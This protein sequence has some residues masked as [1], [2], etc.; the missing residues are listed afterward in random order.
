MFRRFCTVLFYVVLSF[1]FA[2]L[3]FGCKDKKVY[4]IG[5][6]QCSEDDWRKKMNDEIK[7]EM[8]FHNDAVVEIRSADDNSEK[9]IKDIEYFAKNGFD[10]IVVA[11]NEANALTPV[12]DKV[13]KS[14]IP[15]L[16]FDRNINSESYTAYQGA[17]NIS[18]SRTA[19]EYAKT[20]VKGQCR[21]LEI[22]GLKG[23]TPAD[24]R[25]K[26]FT[27]FVESD[28]NMNI[29]G[30]AYGNWNTDDA[31][32]VADSLIDA[33]PDVNLIYA[34][35]DRMAIAASY[36]IR[37]KGLHDVKIV[38]ID[39]APEIGIKAVMDGVID[40]TFL[41]PTDGYG[42]IRT[43]MSILKGKDYKK[44]TILPTAS[45]VN[46]TN[47]E[48]LLLQNKELQSEANKII[49]LKDR[50]DRYKNELYAQYRFIYAVIAILILSFILIFVI[51]F[52]FKEKKKYQMELA[53]K[54]DLLEK[55][56][57]KEIHLNEEL[58]N[59][60]NSKLMFFTNVSHDLRTPL[61]LIL[62]PILQIYN[63]DNLTNS[64]KSLLRL[65][66]NNVKLL[67]SLIDQIL[68]FHKYENGRL[69]LSLDEVDLS[70]L[71]KDWCDS[72]MNIAVSKDIEYNIIIPDNEDFTL[73]ID[74]EKMERV[75]FNLISN[76]FKYTEP[77]DKITVSINKTDNNVSIEVKDSGIGISENAIKHIFDYSF[78]ESRLSSEGSGIGL[79]IAKSFT[80]LHGGTISVESK[81][82][83]GT[84]FTIY[85][86]IKHIDKSE[87]IISDYKPQEYSDIEI[88]SHDTNAESVDFDKTT[89]LIIDDN[90]DIRSLI[91]GL[92]SDKYM[93]LEAADGY[94]GLKKAI[95]YIPDL[96]I[97]D[98]MMNGIDGMELC[99]KIKHEQN[100]SH[101]PIL[102]LTAC[103]MDEQRIKCYESG[104]DAYI[105]KPFNPE[106]LLA[107]CSSLIENN[108]RL[109]NLPLLPSDYTSS[110]EFLKDV[111]RSYDLGRD[112]DS[113]LYTRVC[114]IIEDQ[115][116]DSN[117][118]VDSIASQVGLGRTQF[119]RKIK[120]ITNYSPVELLRNI[121]LAKA[122]NLLL[123]TEKT[124]SEIGY[125]VGFSTP[126][127]FGK[128]YKDRYNETPS[129]VRETNSHK[130]KSKNPS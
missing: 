49:K 17:D 105:S 80:E 45:V 8:M 93:I 22:R 40:A 84:T 127:Y 9:Q 20:L 103:S 98:V 58:R 89:I 19:A 126:A 66:N 1:F 30:S 114:R 101:I 70:V 13:Y 42:L 107:R 32:H 104:A 90:K 14:G 106:L 68:D 53:E 57:D 25:H 77:N 46:S 60:I 64:Q 35:N 16:M 81:K 72:F 74:V 111:N 91:K 21:I 44:M 130:S 29:L 18:I 41:Y 5:I 28:S 85:I 48:I 73:A 128:C 31:T 62:A 37:K 115:M 88:E 123:S 94:N 59:A 3:S 54:N 12:I 47:A 56:I 6:S 100:T 119:Y 43:A 23:S 78:Q 51:L 109:K 67:K 102:I 99:K 15:I 118:S 24:D 33:H 87:A 125:E 97:C 61:T 110:K 71:M 120:A 39:A 112:I 92:F 79:F 69:E 38:G 108:M 124:V 26:G 11:P 7:R 65:A 2:M 27:D 117:L 55:Q 113:E 86:P 36:V 121:R 122:R 34:H 116:S 76:A 95:K 10:I 83:E 129:E 82:G 63:A 4:K 52:R 96:I 75:V 50:A